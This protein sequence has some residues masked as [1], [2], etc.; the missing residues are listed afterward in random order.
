MNILAAEAGSWSKARTACC[1]AAKTLVVLTARSR[2]KP[3]TEDENGCFASFL[4]AAPAFF[5]GD[6]SGGRCRVVDGF[7]PL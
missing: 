4:V 7:L 3:V 1:A 2:V 5:P 6:V